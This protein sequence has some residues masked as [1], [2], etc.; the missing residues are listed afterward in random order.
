MCL[1]NLWYVHS[2]VGNAV[3]PMSKPKRDKGYEDT[4]HGTI[5]LIYLFILDT[6]LYSIKN[7]PLCNACSWNVG[8]SLIF[9]FFQAVKGKHLLGDISYHDMDL[10]FLSHCV[11]IQTA[12]LWSTVKYRHGNMR[13]GRCGCAQQWAG[14]SYMKKRCLKLLSLN[15]H[16]CQSWIQAPTSAIMIDQPP[17]KPSDHRKG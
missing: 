12:T 13:E 4:V 1:V 3:L 11:Q 17:K 7:C 9:A 8:Y 6:Q 16:L 5:K 2:H 10:I 14:H 15:N